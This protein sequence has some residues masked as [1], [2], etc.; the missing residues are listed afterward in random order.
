MRKRQGRPMAVHHL[1][2][3]IEIGASP[4]RVW[5]IL[6]DFPSYPAWNPLVRSVVG[7]PEAG[8]RLRVVIRPGGG[9]N[10]QFSPVVL[11]AM[12]GRELRWLGRLLLPGLLDGEHSFIIDPLGSDRVRFRQGETFSGVLVGLFRGRLERETKR[13]F[14]EMNRALKRRAEGAGHA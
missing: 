10:M 14:E 7:V 1:H 3:E 8:E 12:P 4:E 13:G 11:K 9:R 5:A 2:T 6:A